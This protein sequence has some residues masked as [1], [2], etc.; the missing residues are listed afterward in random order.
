MGDHQ[1]QLVMT[2][3]QAQRPLFVDAGVL[4][5]VDEDNGQS[6]AMSAIISARDWPPL[7]WFRLW[8]RATG[9]GVISLARASTS[10][11]GVSFPLHW[12]WRARNSSTE[13]SSTKRIFCPKWATSWEDK[14][15]RRSAG[16]PGGG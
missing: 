9:S 13:A 15:W 3:K 14:D 5:L 11:G 1:H 2:L 4:N 6:R 8:P 16:A 10:T 12:A 7:S